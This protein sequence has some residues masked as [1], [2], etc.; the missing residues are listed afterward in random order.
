MR[1][2]RLLIAS[3]CLTAT[4]GAATAH[5][6]VW[7]KIRSVLLFDASGKIAA[8]RHAWTFDDLYSA[9]A[10]QGIER[11]P[12]TPLTS[13]QLAPIAAQNMED[14]RE[15]AYF[16]SARAGGQKLGFAAP[17]DFSAEEHPDKTLTLHF[18]LPLTS[19]ASAGK[20]FALQVYDP[21]YFVDF[22][23]EATD[24]VT[25]KSAPDGCSVNYFKPKPLV[26]ADAKKLS[27]SFFS[28]LSPGTDF[29]I[30]LAGRVIV[31][32]P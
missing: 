10:T 6:H 13:E 18:T 23:F 27:E 4:T 14:L 21:S 26:E 2:L 16:T 3:I 22:E 17:V 12:D 9:F 28:G 15:Y 20:A 5:P 30:K 24:P 8:I 32:C 25:L 29:G 1:S 31:G 7:V 19:A 11:K